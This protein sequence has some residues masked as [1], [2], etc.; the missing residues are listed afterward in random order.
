MPV[1]TVGINNSANAAL[2]AIRLLGAFMP[3]LQEK[4]EMYQLQIGKQV[5]DKAS[6]L[7]ELGIE[8]Y[9]ATKNKK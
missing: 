8:A 7:R 5:E 6:L 4:M 2:L 1:A 9:L 3:A